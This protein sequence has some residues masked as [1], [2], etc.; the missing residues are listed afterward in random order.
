MGNFS[1][2][3]FEMQISISSGFS[4]PLECLDIGPAINKIMLTLSAFVIAV[5]L[6]PEPEY[7]QGDARKDE[8]LAVTARP[9]S[10]LALPGDWPPSPVY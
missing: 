5:V 8:G 9:R 7:G 2:G 4:I 10:H 3:F 6:Q 1:I